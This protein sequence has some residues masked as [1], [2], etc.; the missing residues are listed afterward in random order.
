MPKGP[1]SFPRLN[2]QYVLYEASEPRQR[3]LQ[4]AHSVS[5]APVVNVDH[6]VAL[7]DHHCLRLPTPLHILPALAKH[8]RVDPAC[9]VRLG[10]VRVPFV[11]L[12]RRILDGE[13][14]VVRP[15]LR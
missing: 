2:G 10:V 3:Y 14:L 13:V 4:A 11:F 1:T 8:P 6:A 7:L 9:Q 15:S 5:N 12:Y